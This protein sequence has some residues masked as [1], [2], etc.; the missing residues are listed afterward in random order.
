MVVI[1]EIVA[2]LGLINKYYFNNTT[3]DMDKCDWYLC[4]GD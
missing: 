3:S 1:N 4:G 2:P